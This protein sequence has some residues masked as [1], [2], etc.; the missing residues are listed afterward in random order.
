MENI[1]YDRA[2]L[3][4]FLNISAYFVMNGAGLFETLVLVPAWT[5]APPASLHF[6]RGPYGLDLKAFWIGMH[7][8]HEIIFILSIVFNWGIRRRRYALLAL[9]GIH[10]AIR[11]WTV[12]YFAPAIMWFQEIPESGAVDAALQAKAAMWRNLNLLRTGLFVAVNLALIPLLP[13]KN[14]A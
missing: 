4:L 14:K 1:N 3:W 5:A 10:M 9:F 13:L 7:S 2:N 12:M 8:V 6:F 11:V